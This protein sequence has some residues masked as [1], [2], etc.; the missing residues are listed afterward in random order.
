VT[1]LAKRAVV[2]IVVL[3]LIGL[4]AV[5]AASNLLNIGP[6]QKT[7]DVQDAVP[8]EGKYG[9]Y[10]LDLATEKVRLL[11]STDNEIY[12]SALRLNK[13]G[14]K[15]VF[16]QKTDGSSDESTEI[17]T[18]NV[19][20][21]NLKRL[22]DNSYWDL[23][24]VWSP[25]GARIAFLSKRDNDLDIYMM[26][27]DGSNHH[28]FYDSGSHDADI[29]WAADIIVFTSGS[30]IWSIKDDGTGLTQITN[31]A[32][33][34]RWGQANLPIGDYDPRLRSDGL[35]IVFERLEDPESAHGGYNIFSVNS[36]GTQETRLTNTGYAQ[37]LASWSHSG[38]R[39]VYGVAAIGDEGKYDMYM[40]DAEGSDNHSV[41]PE[42]F[43]SNFLCYSPM[44]SLDDSEI[45]FIG[46]WYG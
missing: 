44:F 30:K 31:P 12:T 15:L 46:Q 27:A 39:I 28:L 24:P 26:N 17:F 4:L 5:V 13:Q 25:D 35:K 11:Y 2:A 34:G 10:V 32:D 18:I 37:G 3:A 6:F 1:K 19:D 16:A 14:E 38:D 42:Y 21:H 8:H 40:M 7:P 23:Y 22:T 45:Y 41:T 33:A 20:G 9:I 29:D 36:D 43:A